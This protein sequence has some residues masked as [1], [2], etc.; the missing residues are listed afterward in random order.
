M[1]F[2][3][4]FILWV[5]SAVQLASAAPILQRAPTPSGWFAPI[6]TVGG[7]PLPPDLTLFDMLFNSLPVE[8]TREITS[9]FSPP[10][11]DR[12]PPVVDPSIFDLLKGIETKREASI[13]GLDPIRSTTIDPSILS[14][15][16]DAA[17]KRS[18][19]DTILSDPFFNGINRV[20][21]PLIDP[22][23]FNG[24]L[25]DVKTKR[26][27]AEDILFKNFDPAALLAIAE[28]KIKRETETFDI[29]PGLKQPL[30]VDPTIPVI[31]DLVPVPLD[32]APLDQAENNVKRDIDTFDIFP[33]L[34]Q[35]LVVDPMIPVRSD[36]APVPLDRRLKFSDPCK[37]PVGFEGIIPIECTAPEFVPL[38][39][40]P[41]VAQPGTDIAN[42]EDVRKRVNCNIPVGFAGL[43]PPECLEGQVF[44]D[45][46]NA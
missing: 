17:R 39:T 4:T 37:F 32:P 42:A 46:F 44:P 29:F 3:A 24:L 28:K 43:I 6:P 8:E 14:L 13:E 35:P 45:L 25:N 19:A 20:P 9:P 18:L 10:H 31:S 22:S 36:L 16:L 12:V 30:V 38:P 2:S 11:I 7:L 5:A 40:L 41:E 34:K 23:I 21:P 15:L 26:L 33:G 1:K 27:V